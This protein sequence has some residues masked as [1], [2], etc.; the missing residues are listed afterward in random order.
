MG[1]EESSKPP[2]PPW[3]PPTEAKT[4]APPRTE[5]KTPALSLAEATSQMRHDEQSPNNNQQMMYCFM[6]MMSQDGQMMWS[7]QL[8]PQY[9]AQVSDTAAKL[10][11]YEA[12]AREL[13]LVAAQYAAA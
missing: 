9:Q 2:L 11:E 10:H 7:Y 12:K 6:P 3:F 1:H 13:E 8:Q 4:L 5:A